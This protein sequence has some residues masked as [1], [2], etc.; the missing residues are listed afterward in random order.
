MH[1]GYHVPAVPTRERRVRVLVLVV[2]LTAAL[3]GRDIV[4]TATC[5]ARPNGAGGRATCQADV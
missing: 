1:R 2:W 3:F 5:G 4:S